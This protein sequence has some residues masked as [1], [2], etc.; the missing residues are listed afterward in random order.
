MVGSSESRAEH[1]RSAVAGNVSLAVELALEMSPRAVDAAITDDFTDDEAN[2]RATDDFFLRWLGALPALERLAAARQVSGRYVLDLVWLPGSYDKSVGIEL[3][4]LGSALEHLA[5]DFDYLRDVSE[6][7]DA[8]FGLPLSS[9]TSGSPCSFG[10]L[11][12][13]PLPT[14]VS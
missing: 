6:S 2:A 9:G 10:P 11:P 7:P 8:T 4:A 1:L 14:A 3:S 13:L 12:Q 5:D